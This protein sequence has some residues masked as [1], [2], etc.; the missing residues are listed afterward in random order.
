MGG[1]VDVQNLEIQLRSTYRDLEAWAVSRER[2]SAATRKEHLKYMLEFQQQ[3]QQLDER[4]RHLHSFS[5]EVK[6][7]MQ[8][9]R[10]E[11]DALKEVAA[12]FENENGKLE[13]EVRE[14]RDRVALEELQYRIKITSLDDKHNKAEAQVA[15]MKKSALLYRK[16]LGLKLRQTSNELVFGFTQ[17]DPSDPQREFQFSLRISEDDKFHV[18]AC[19]PP[20]PSLTQ[21]VS[22][23]NATNNFAQFVKRIRNEFVKASGTDHSSAAR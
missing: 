9:Q 10:A 1:L 15:L 14:V 3:Q 5:E 11:M 2:D 13:R 18:T 20:L 23:L 4:L 17:I 16:R 7:K 22:N 8:Q 19:D 12:K 21:L 6:V